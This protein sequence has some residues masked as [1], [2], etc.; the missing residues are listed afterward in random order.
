MDPTNSH[1][2]YNLGVLYNMEKGSVEKAK[3]L[4]NKSLYVNI[5][6][7]HD[8]ENNKEYDKF[9]ESLDRLSEGKNQNLGR[10]WWQWWFGTSKNMD[11]KNAEQNILKQFFS[12]YGRKITGILLLLI[13]SALVIKL[14]YD[15]FLHDYLN[16][17]YN[18]T[19]TIH[20]HTL[21]N[22][23]FILLGV[24]IAI[25]L[26]PVISRLKIADV[27]VEIPVESKGNQIYQLMP[28]PN[29]AMRRDV[30][31]NLDFGLFIVDLWY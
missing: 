7:V 31:L 23:D 15:L 29:S 27:E 2:Y 9:K 21:S 26:L 17:M 25:L 13:I 4:I 16:L 6:N 20:S 12:R 28:L 10:G 5:E 11:K 24:N 30:H 22:T 19:Y 18:S 8:V 1:S 3:K 14:N